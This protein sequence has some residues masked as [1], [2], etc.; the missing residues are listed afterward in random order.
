MTDITRLEAALPGL[1][2]RIPLPVS[3]GSKN[4]FACRICMASGGLVI[5]STHQWATVGEAHDHIQGHL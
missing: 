5:T 1:P 4:T 2:W 3:W